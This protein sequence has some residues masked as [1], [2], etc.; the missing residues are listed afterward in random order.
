[1][2]YT[3]GKVVYEK[4]PTQESET[5]II[6]PQASPPWCMRRNNSTASLL[7]FGILT[8]RCLLLWAPQVVSSN[9]NPMAF[10]LSSKESL[11]INQ[12]LVISSVVSSTMFLASIYDG[13]V[14]IIR[15]RRTKDLEKERNANLVNASDTFLHRE[16]EAS[17]TQHPETIIK[18]KSDLKLMTDL[19]NDRSKL[20]N[21]SLLDQE[22]HMCQDSRSN[23]NMSIGLDKEDLQEDKGQKFR[24]LSETLDSVTQESPSPTFLG[25]R[26]IRKIVNTEAEQNSSKLAPKEALKNAN[27]IIL[28]PK[29]MQ[30][31]TEGASHS[32][33]DQSNGGEKYCSIKG[34][35]PAAADAVTN[36]LTHPANRQLHGS[37]FQ[38]ATEQREGDFEVT[39]DVLAPK[40]ITSP[41]NDQDL[42]MELR[43]DSSRTEKEVVVEIYDG[44]QLN[45]PRRRKDP[46]IEDRFWSLF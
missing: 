12:S 16:V 45:E 44:S 10:K 29:I 6:Y 20:R 31:S 28:L 40:S 14:H 39:G 32:K 13:K 11:R 18:S 5:S 33:E 38:V 21:L 46:V 26:N 3:K 4:N 23:E 9:E 35:S 43:F 19:V 2:Y 41:L 42:G 17:A 37:D 22:E 1:M 34:I 25:T 27:G 36:E 15:A 30:K 8:Q 24:R 7:V